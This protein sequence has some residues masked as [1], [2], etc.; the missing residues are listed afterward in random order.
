MTANLRSQ[1]WWTAADA[2]EFDAIVHE[3]IDS[4]SSHREAGCETCAA[5]HPPCPK[6]QKAIALTLEWREARILLSRAK[7]E[8]TTQNLFEFERELDELLARRARSAA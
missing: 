7:W 8:R 1:P 4:V 3:L 2:A 5:G 6:V